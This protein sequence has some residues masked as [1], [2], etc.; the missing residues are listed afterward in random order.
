MITTIFITILIVVI[1][2]LLFLLTLLYPYFSTV[3][4]PKITLPTVTP[5]HTSL[6]P[7]LIHR[8]WHTVDVNLSMH[9]DVYQRWITL[10]PSYTMMW[11]TMD[12]CEA[13]LKQFSQEAYN[14]Y[15]RL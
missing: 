13:S 11:Y 10:N 15:K 1:I 12:D 4:V 6:I 3:T 5:S 14:A 8:T 7:K 2:V 9:H